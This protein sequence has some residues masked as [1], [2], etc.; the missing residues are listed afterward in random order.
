MNELCIFFNFLKLAN[1]RQALHRFLNRTNAIPQVKLMWTRQRMCCSR[2]IVQFQKML[3]YFPESLQDQAC[4]SNFISFFKK[5]KPRFCITLSVHR[6]CSET[7]CWAWK[8]GNLSE[9]P[10]SF[11]FGCSGDI[12]PS[13]FFRLFNLH[14]KYEELGTG[15]IVFSS[16]FKN[17]SVLPSVGGC[18]SHAWLSCICVCLHMYLCLWEEEI[19]FFEMYGISAALS[20]VPL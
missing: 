10:P 3:R 13:F 6:L 11:S 5:N 20:P 4:F 15:R 1:F 16:S 14:R 8:N 9:A 19:A 7:V 18:W 2:M 17:K 12:F